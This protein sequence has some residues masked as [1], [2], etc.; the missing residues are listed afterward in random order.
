MGD[1]VIS[2]FSKLMQKVVKSPGEEGSHGEAGEVI[3]EFDFFEFQNHQ[4]D[5]ENQHARDRVGRIHQMI[6][7]EHGFEAVHEQRNRALIDKHRHCG[8]RDAAAIDADEAHRGQSI[9]H[10]LDGERLPVSRKAVLHRAD[11]PERPGAKQNGADDKTFVEAVWVAGTHYGEAGTGI[12]SEAIETSLNM[13][14]PT[15]KAAQDKRQNENQ[16]CAQKVRRAASQTRPGHLQTEDD[17]D[18][19]HDAAPG[20]LSR[21]GELPRQHQPHETADEDANGIEDSPR[22][23]RQHAKTETRGGAGSKAKERAETAEALSMNRLFKA[24]EPRKRGTPNFSP[25]RVG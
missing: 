12:F 5:A 20:E 2:V 24:G 22:H 8:Q 10:H 21:R 11:D 16:Q 23:S 3:A 18:N 9:H 1:P 6:V 4:R 7:L 25:S 17:G 15:R 14:Q 13:K 19:A